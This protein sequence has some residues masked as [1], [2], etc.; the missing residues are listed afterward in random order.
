MDIDSVSNITVDGL[1]PGMIL[2]M[3]DIAVQYGSTL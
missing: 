3:D 2:A 1:M